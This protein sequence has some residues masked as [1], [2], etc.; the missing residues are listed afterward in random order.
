MRVAPRPKFRSNA[1]ITK[2]S[3]L[4]SLGTLASKHFIITL[5]RRKLLNS[6]ATVLN[7]TKSRKMRRMRKEAIR[8]RNSDLKILSSTLMASEK[9]NQSQERS[10]LCSWWLTSFSTP[11]PF[12]SLSTL[13]V[14]ATT[15]ARW[16]S[17]LKELTTRTILHPKLF[18]ASM[19]SLRHS[20]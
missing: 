12:T 4:A 15:G 13:V 14:R 9:L 16:S 11:C 2:I 1:S 5:L 10:S 6:S 20:P 19:A 7:K 3:T 17:S 18:K 8:I